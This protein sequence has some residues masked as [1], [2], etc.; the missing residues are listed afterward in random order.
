MNFW[1]FYR[2]IDLYIFFVRVFFVEE[3]V[4]NFFFLVCFSFL[5]DFFFVGFCVYGGDEGLE[6]EDV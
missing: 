6:E 3:K 1:V 4:V 2:V 5:G